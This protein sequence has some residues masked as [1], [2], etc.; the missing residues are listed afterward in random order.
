MGSFNPLEESILGFLREKCKNRITRRITV[1]EGKVLLAVETD[2][3]AGVV[4]LTE[5]FACA[6]SAEPV[7]AGSVEEIAEKAATGSGKIYREMSVCGSQPFA[8][9]LSF[10][11]G[12]EQ[13]ASELQKAVAEIAT[14]GNTYGIPVVGGD[15][16]FNSSQKRDIAAN[17]LTISLID[18]DEQFV[19][20][21]CDAGNPV[22]IVGAPDS[23]KQISSSAFITRSLYE[24]ICDLHE[25]NAIV[26]V[27]TINGDG[28]VTSSETL[29]IRTCAAMVAEGTHGIE[30]NIPHRLSDRFAAGKPNFAEDKL[31]MVIGKNYGK[32]LEKACHKW[33]MRCVQVGVVT[34][35]HKLSV[36][37][38]N[39]VEL[40]LPASVLPVFD[41]GSFSENEDETSPAVANALS[42]TELPIPDD[43]KEVAKFLTTCPNLS[44]QQWIFE[45]F[46][47][48]VGANNLSTNFI[49]DAAV[50]QIKGTRHAIA[51]SF[52]QNNSDLVKYP[53]AVNIVVAEA[54]HKVICSG[55]DPRTLTGC[56]NYGGCIDENILRTI[57]INIA[58]F[59]KK[60]GIA[61]SGITIN[62][63]VADGAP[64][65]FNLSIGAIAFINDRQL[66]MTMSFKGKGDMIYMLGNSVDN[67]NSSEYIRNY[68]KIDDSQPQLVDLDAEIKL[69]SISQHLISRKLVNSAQNVSRGGLFMALLKSAMVRSFGFDVTTD[70]EIRKDSFLFGES[71]SRVIVSVASQ[72]EAN[73]IDYMIDSGVPF[74]TLGHVTREE[75]RVDDN[76]YG[77]ISDYKKRMYETR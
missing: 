6:F 44:S 53:E 46:D 60:M 51:T 4:E 37:K 20:C 68:H 8:T 42:S 55:G 64:T 49:S 30:L 43:H 40:N 27:E 22:Y 1:D 10:S 47:S 58:Q 54:L 71:P 50:L 75:I 52:C 23:G 72:R 57:N 5:D 63:V 19:S 76:S 24:L 31:I 21:C 29:I 59:C 14:Y 77:F 66:Q 74:I 65:I 45:Q 41:G 25:D 61:T 2:E 48:T 62:H 9:L 36:I 13:G 56:L 69:M 7:Y 67:I 39:K 38:D 16:R 18:M 73:F 70:D 26:A 32:K 35:E 33:N 3:Q 11:T 15:M 34:H 17:M 28:T 12:V